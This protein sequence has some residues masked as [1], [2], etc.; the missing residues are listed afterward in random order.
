MKIIFATT[1]ERKLLDVR[2]VIEHE[3]FD[4]EILSLNDIGFIGDIEE[5]GKTLEDNSIIKAKA[6]K[7][8][9]NTRNI[10]Y[11]IIS[12]DSG[13]F[14]NSLNGEPGI[15]TSRYAEEEIKANPLLPKYEC[16]NKALRKLE[17]S[18]NRSA[19]F[20][21]A[22]TCITEDNAVITATSVTNG[23]I[24]N[25]IQGE[26]ANPYFYSVFIPV[27]SD[28]TLN[29]FNEEELFDTCRYLGFKSLLGKICNVKSKK[30]RV[31]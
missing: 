30:L 23:S 9:C 5:T 24:S 21:C 28:K 22:L 14:I 4:A 1:N 17:N 3:D 20:R 19:Q 26:I 29:Q 8:F 11:T 25:S 27:G 16:V 6:V 12:D 10:N 15:N 31:E 13:L 18:N 7:I 2:S